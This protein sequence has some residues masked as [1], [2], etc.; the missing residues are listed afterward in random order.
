VSFLLK[1]FFWRIQELESVRGIASR[2]VAEGFEELLGGFSRAVVAAGGPVSQC[3]SPV[4]M[5]PCA[6]NRN[7]P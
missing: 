4:K 2:A 3:C 5:S 7:V 6:P 1:S